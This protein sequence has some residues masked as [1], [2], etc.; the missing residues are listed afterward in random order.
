MARRN[1]GRELLSKPTGREAGSLFMEE[2][3]LNDGSNRD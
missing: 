2:G 3:N 1:F